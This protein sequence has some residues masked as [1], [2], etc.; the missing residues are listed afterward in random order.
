MEEGAFKIKCVGSA[1]RPPNNSTSLTSLGA[2]FV[3]I[4][5]ESPGPDEY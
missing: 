1:E 4:E 5:E 2:S 3:Y